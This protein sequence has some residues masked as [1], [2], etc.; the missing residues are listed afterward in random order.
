MWP[1]QGSFSSCH[2]FPVTFP[3]QCYERDKLIYEEHPHILS[4]QVYESVVN[5]TNTV[6]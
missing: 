6:H 1:T 2:A 4:H 3:L 5:H